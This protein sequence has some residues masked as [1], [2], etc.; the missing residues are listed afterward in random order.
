MTTACQSGGP[1]TAGVLGDS[2]Y[3][4]AMAGLQRIHDERVRTPMPPVPI[5]PGPNG[6]APT[7]EAQRRRDSVVRHRADSIVA[8]DSVKRLAIFSQYRVTV[9]TLEATARALAGD[10]A[11]LQR[12]NDAVYRR[13]TVLDAAANLAKT[14][15]AKSGATATSPAPSAAAPAKP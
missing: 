3:V 7:P 12:V 2:T 14:P 9:A 13:M 8:V 6:S 10:P 5:V 11:R 1:P 15:G 4:A